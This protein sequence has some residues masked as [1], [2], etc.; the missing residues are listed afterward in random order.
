MEKFIILDEKKDYKDST[1]V[2][3][4]ED[5][6]EKETAI[7]F[8]FEILVLPSKYEN[9]NSTYLDFIKTP[10]EFRKGKIIYV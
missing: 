5:D 7:G 6:I 8:G 1:M 3:L 10:L 4:S 2:I 9:I